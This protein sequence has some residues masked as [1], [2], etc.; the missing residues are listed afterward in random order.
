MTRG[1]ILSLKH[2]TSQSSSE[3][4]TARNMQKHD[5]ATTALGIRVNTQD[6][7]IVLSLYARSC[8]L[9]S[10]PSLIYMRAFKLHTT[11]S[12]I[13]SSIRDVQPPLLATNDLTK[14]PL[15]IIYG[16]HYILLREQAFHLIFKQA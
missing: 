9:Y 4:R 6:V 8:L 10:L 13:S 15:Q 11:Q 2:N 14:C 3:L 12:S 7:S 16:A 1:S 5:A